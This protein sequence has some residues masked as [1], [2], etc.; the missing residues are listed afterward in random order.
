MVN[1]AGEN[2]IIQE[3]NENNETL[4]TVI[5]FTKK[6][7]QSDEKGKHFFLRKTPNETDK[8]RKKWSSPIN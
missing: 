8:E 4:N 2:L 6:I 3:K 5:S 7:K 1:E